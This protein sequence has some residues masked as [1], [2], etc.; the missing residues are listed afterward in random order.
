MSVLENRSKTLKRREEKERKTS[1]NNLT[2]YLETE[3]RKRKLS[4]KQTK[5]K[6][7]IKISRK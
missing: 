2:F 3:K 5:R 6:K 1:I 4:L 7:R